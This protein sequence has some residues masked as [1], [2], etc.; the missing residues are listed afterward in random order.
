[1]SITFEPS[2]A[3]VSRGW[4]L[5][6]ASWRR[7]TEASANHAEDRKIAEAIGQLS[8]FNDRELSDIGLGRSDLTPEGLA[9][10]GTRRSLR[11]AALDAE[12][13]ARR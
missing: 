2:A 4:M 12:I 10:A 11:Q 3:G 8:Q 9:T 6:T 13:A 5:L 1:M 7:L